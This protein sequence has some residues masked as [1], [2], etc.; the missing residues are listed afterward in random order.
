MSTLRFVKNNSFGF[1]WTR[2]SER[3]R[4]RRKRDIDIL[5]AGSFSKCPQ[6]PGSE[7][8]QYSFPLRLSG[9]NPCGWQEPTC[10]SHHCALPRS[11]LARSWCQEPEPGFAGPPMWGAGILSHILI[12][13]PNTGPSYMRFIFIC[14]VKIKDTDVVPLRTQL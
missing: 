3:E 8:T 7:H 5:S 9:R 2:M 1:C 11:V 14:L 12:T 6:W 10:L 13:R 4:E